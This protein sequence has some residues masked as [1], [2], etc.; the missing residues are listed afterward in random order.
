[1]SSIIEWGRCA[2]HSRTSRGRVSNKYL[3]WF[4]T[5]RSTAGHRRVQGFLPADI[6][7]AFPERS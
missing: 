2:G 5:A 6:G 7:K 3:P 1:M 4:G